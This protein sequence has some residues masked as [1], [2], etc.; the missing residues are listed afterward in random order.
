MLHVASSR[1]HQ[2]CVQFLLEGTVAANGMLDDQDKWG[3]TALHLAVRKRHAQVGIYN[4]WSDGFHRKRTCH[5][6]RRG[7]CMTK[8]IFLT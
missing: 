7:N 6:R 1:G 2:A 8:A 5:C 4:G 3:N